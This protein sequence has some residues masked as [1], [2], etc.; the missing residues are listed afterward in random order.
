MRAWQVTRHGEPSDVLELVQL[1]VPAPGPGQ[2]LVR[3]AASACNFPD[4]LLCHGTY[5]ERPPLPFTPGLEISGEVV[6]TGQGAGAAAGDRVI[7]TPALPSGGYAEHVLLDTWYPWPDGMTPGQAAGLFITY[8]TGVCALHHRAGLRSGE[9][10]LVHAAAGGVGSA[11]VQVGKAAGATVIG[12]AGGGDKC[13]TARTLGADHVV[14]YRD[15][16]VVAAVKEITGGH[17]ADV[18]FDPV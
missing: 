10:L 16:D 5:Q 15:T 8:Q 13:A 12:T 9:V 11:A 3:V 1:P 18:V 17:G 4:V 14:D 7:G 6:A 2:V